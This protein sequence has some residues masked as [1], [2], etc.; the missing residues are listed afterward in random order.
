MKNL[1]LLMTLIHEGPSDI[2][3]SSTVELKAIKTALENSVKGGA[4]DNHNIIVES[5]SFTVVNW[6]QKGSD[7]PWSL[8]QDLNAIRNSC[9]ILS[10]ITVNH[11]WR[12]SNHV[13]DALAKQGASRKELFMAW[14]SVEG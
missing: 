11:V 8:T 7:T 9:T 5:D 1:L 3:N 14:I 10:N 13:T 4:L 6:L 12:E 2:L